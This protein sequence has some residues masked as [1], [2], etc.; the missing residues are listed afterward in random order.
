MKTKLFIYP[1]NNNENQYINI[2]EKAIK[3]CGINV[4]YSLK[5]F[6]STDFFLLN[7][8]ETLG[9]NIKLDYIKKCIKIFFMVLF[10]K[11][12]FWVVHNKQPHTKYSDDKSISLSIKLMKKLLKVSTRI[13]ILC[14]E[15]KNVLSK[16]CGNNNIYEKKLY[17]IPHPNY[18]GIYPNHCI[19]KTQNKLNFLYIGQVNK[20]KNVDLLIN[21]FNELKD[22]NI[23]LTIAGNCKDK[24]YI[25]QL[26]DLISNKNIF[27]DFRFI[28]DNEIISYINKSEILV[29]PYSLDSSLNSGTIFLAFSYKKTVISPLIG[30]LKEYEKNNSFF[31]SYEY[32]TEE[33]HKTNLLETIKQVIS[34][35][36]IDKNILEKKGIE[37]Y[38]FIAKNNSVEIITNLYKNLFSQFKFKS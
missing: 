13:I 16:L 35:Y 32:K 5:D 10:R 15:T 12:I 2:Q 23:S 29:L 14:E 38:N 31:Y 1:A 37:G 21:I 28:P 9:G 22:E 3:E 8:F 27:C 33:E 25:K 6:F 24:N 7:W 17:K 19:T 26:Y 20:Y 11:K 18:I 36:T 30:T 34:D 4:T